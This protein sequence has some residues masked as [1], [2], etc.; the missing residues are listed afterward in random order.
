MPAL[1]IIFVRIRAILMDIIEY[2]TCTLLEIGFHAHVVYLYAL[3]RVIYV[4]P[5]LIIIGLCVYYPAVPALSL[6]SIHVH[7]PMP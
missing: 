6:S 4:V 2:R 3:Y 7:T 5:A 1:I